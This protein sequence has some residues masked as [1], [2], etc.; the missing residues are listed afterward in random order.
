MLNGNNVAHLIVNNLG[1]ITTLTQNLI[2]NKGIDDLP[3]ELFLLN[4]IGNKNNSANDVINSEIKPF[5]LN[6]DPKQNWYHCFRKIANSLSLNS[7]IL[8][9]NDQYD[10][11]MLLQ[12]NI[13]RKVVQLVHDDYNLSLSLKFH[14]CI[15]RFISHNKFIYTSLCNL[16]PTRQNDIHFLNYGIPLFKNYNAKLNS[17]L[18]LLFLGRHDIQKGIYDLFEIEE[19]LQI[20]NVLVNWTIL[21][22]GPETESIKLEAAAAARL[23]LLRATL[24]HP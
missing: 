5:H 9:S 6:F 11:I 14:H 12:F 19:I 8:V 21:G 17:T 13:P 16:L 15:D 22:K 24:E 10:L 20:N 2:L 23:P 1:G 7:G 18:N 4:V 3:Q